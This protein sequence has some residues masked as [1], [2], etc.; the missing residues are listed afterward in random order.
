MKLELEFKSVAK[1]GLPDKSGTYIVICKRTDETGDCWGY[2]CAINYS[3]RH[4]AFNAYDLHETTEYAF[5]DVVAYCEV[6]QEWA[7]KV[8]N[9]LEVKND[10]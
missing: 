4:K 3:S 2:F 8:A 10:G 1:D 9:E 7:D 5:D 6:P